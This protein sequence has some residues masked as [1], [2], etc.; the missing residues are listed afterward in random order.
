MRSEDNR[1]G[2]RVLTGNGECD[3]SGPALPEFLTNDLVSEIR[4]VAV[5]AQMRQ[6]NVTESVG[7]NFAKQ[8][9]RCVVAEVTVPAHN[10]L[11]QRPW[12]HG[13][14]LKQF[15]IV[16]GFDDERISRTH[17]FDDKLRD[18]TKVGEYADNLVAMP[19]NETDRIVSVVRNAKRFDG[20]IANRER[21]AGGKQSPRNADTAVRLRIGGNRFGGQPVRINREGPVFA[22][23]SQTARVI[24]MFVRENDPVN[25]I[26]PAADFLQALRDLSSTETGIHQDAGGCGFNQCTISGTAAPQNRN[27][28]PHAPILHALPFHSS[29]FALSERKCEATERFFHLDK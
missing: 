18:V 8:S 16:I 29:R 2:R 27:L 24:G 22:K 3:M 14:I 1:T 9:S 20:Q 5:S 28:H 26:E 12:P 23:N 7:C 6:E 15:Q 11:L 10:A 17:T 25:V 19:D 13:I 4:P 21:R